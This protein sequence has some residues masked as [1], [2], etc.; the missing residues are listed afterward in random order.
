M[1]KTKRLYFRI[2]AALS[3]IAA[4]FLSA[5]AGSKWY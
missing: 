2:A 4:L 5:G 1:K 3:T